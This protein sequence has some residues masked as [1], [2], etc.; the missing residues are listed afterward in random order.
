MTCQHKDL[1]RRHKDLASRHDYLTRD[2]RNMPLY[3]IDMN[4]CHQVSIYAVAIQF[5]S[6]K[7]ERKFMIKYT[8]CRIC[9]VYTLCA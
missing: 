2:R 8:D 7:L 9:N 6:V 1:T 4:I 3:F 5:F